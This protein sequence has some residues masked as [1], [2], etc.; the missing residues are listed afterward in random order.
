MPVGLRAPTVGPS[1][2]DEDIDEGVRYVSAA[3]QPKRFIGVTTHGIAGIVTSTGNADC[4]H[5]VRGGRGGAGERA[6]RVIGAAAKGPTIAACG[7]VGVGVSEQAELAKALAD[8]V[9]DGRAPGLKGISLSS[10]LLAGRQVATTTTR[11]PQQRTSRASTVGPHN[12]H[13]TSPTTTT[14]PRRVGAR[15]E[16]RRHTVYGLACDRERGASPC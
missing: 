1:A 5:V 6:K 2:A 3:A 14:G 7:G 8:A 12:N 9:G 13:N 11:P 4:V 15:Y 16:R 10:H